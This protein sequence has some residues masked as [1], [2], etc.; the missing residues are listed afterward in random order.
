MNDSRRVPGRT[1]LVSRNIRLNGRRTSIKLEPA[2]WSALGRVA[3]E[4][5]VSIHEICQSVAERTEGYGL[6]GAVRVFLLC[7]MS[8][9][10][11]VSALEA[12]PVG[13]LPA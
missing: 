12:V 7:Y 3:E 4:E 5:G 8:G 2:F 10:S 1:A 13:D 6:T 9:A 11:Y